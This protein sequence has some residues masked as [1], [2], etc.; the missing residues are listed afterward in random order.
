MR[1]SHSGADH[2]AWSPAMPARKRRI[3]ETD[4]AVQ[5]RDKLRTEL[6]EMEME[7]E[8]EGGARKRRGRRGGKDGRGDGEREA[9]IDQFVFSVPSL[10]LLLLR[11]L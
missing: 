2:A 9:E 4:V 10:L 8:M 3:S 1:F 6:D 5:H 7:L 11:E